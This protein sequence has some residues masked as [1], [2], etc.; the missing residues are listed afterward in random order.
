MSAINGH[1][2]KVHFFHRYYCFLGSALS[3]LSVNMILFKV[4]GAISPVIVNVCTYGSVYTK[5]LCK[6]VVSFAS[7]RV[8]VIAIEIV[9]YCTKISTKRCETSNR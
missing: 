6:F 4:T 5:G 8:L 2:L 7:D 1:L 9:R 3:P